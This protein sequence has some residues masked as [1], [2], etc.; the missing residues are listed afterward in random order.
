MKK[1]LTIALFLFA[2]L[3][4][5]A[6]Q[7]KIDTARLAISKAKTDT[8]K[9]V[10][11]LRVMGLYIQNQPDSSLIFN[12]QG[13]LLAKKNN[14]AADQ[15]TS[16]NAMANTYVSMGDYVKASQ[17]YLRA[18][19]I[20]EGL[21]D[22]V[23]MAAVTGNI[24]Y[25]YGQQHDFKQGLAYTITAKKQLE[26]Y[27]LTHKLTARQ[28][29]T[30]VIMFDNLGSFD[31][32]LHSID[33]AEKYLKIA[34][35]MAK[36]FKHDDLLGDVQDYLGKVAAARGKNEEAARF[37]RQAL[38]SDRLIG[39]AEHM[40]IAYLDMA[41][42][43]HKGKQQDSAEYYAKK[44]LETAE[45]GHFEQH[46]LDAGMVLYT[47]YDQDH[48]LGEAY[49]Y[50]KLATAAKDSLYSQDKVKQMLNIDFDEKMR[51]QEIAEAE[52]QYRN[53]VRLYT[54]AA[55]LAVLLFVAVIFWRNSNQRKKANRL[56]SKQK[57]EIEDQ[58][59]QTNKALTE[60]QQTQTQLIQREKMASLGELTAGI[61]HEIQNPLNFVNNFS[62]VSAELVDELD[63]KLAGGDIR[64]ARTIAADVKQ[65]LEKIHHHGKR[66]DSIVKGMLQHSRMSAGQ[67]EL[68]NLNIIAD[69]YLRLAYH[70]LRAADK[71][72]NADVITRFDD[73]LPEAYVIP[74]DM[75]RVFL[76]LFNNAFYAVSQKQKAM[77][78]G[79][80]PEVSVTTYRDNGSIILKVK[81]NGNGIP[82][83]IRQKIM[84]P[85]FTTKP[86]GEGT[87]LG[88]SLTYDIVVKSHSG[89][90]DFTTKVNEY[91]EFIVTLPVASPA[92]VANA[93]I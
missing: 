85:F 31:F 74:Q 22:L 21:H 45:S 39:D 88:L 3:T 72:F 24:G 37:F 86:T 52:I 36:R 79:Y 80:K 12:Q 54:L 82:E 64:E 17:T 23:G 66:A 33:S 81:D 13:Y 29:R 75:G 10:A 43:Y 51:Q 6:Q 25:S 47:Y 73:G 44:A 41:G 40:C 32:E 28:G 14:W 48:N 27:A 19:K 56:L 30:Y 70:G 46:A 62:E 4:V 20:D 53:K 55:G 69:E 63:E 83:G 67:K 15:A 92:A 71:S 35:E 76:N 11:L 8:E 2:L 78:E 1:T 42:L 18:L 16:L 61:A 84:Q 57:K 7:K 68:I 87:G 26:T 34:Y 65:N 9:Y 77:K 50:L 38:A 90:I 5:S 59:D 60:L 49:R 91:T 93:E 58:R 89:S